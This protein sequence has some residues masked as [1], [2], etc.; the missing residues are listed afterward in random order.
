LAPFLF[1]GISRHLP[2]PL[3]DT[4]QRGFANPLAFLNSHKL[5]VFDARKTFDQTVSP[6]DLKIGMGAPSEPKMEPA[7]IH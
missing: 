6:M 2:R 7:I 3:L 1:L 4:L 5:V